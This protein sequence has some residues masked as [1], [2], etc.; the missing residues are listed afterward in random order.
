MDFGILLQKLLSA[1]HY[2]IS[3]HTFPQTR[4]YLC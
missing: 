4:L 3:F 2:E 1:A